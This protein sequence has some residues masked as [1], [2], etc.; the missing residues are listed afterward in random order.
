MPN[1]VYCNFF[2]LKC[3]PGYVLWV[4]FS[5]PDFLMALVGVHLFLFHG[6]YPFG[7]NDSRCLTVYIFV[8][9]FE[10]STYLR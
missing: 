10:F 7:Q 6:L 3:I 5:F 2:S 8:L 1:F 9:C 4:T